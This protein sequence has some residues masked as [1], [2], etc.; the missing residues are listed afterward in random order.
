MRLTILPLPNGAA[1][2]PNFIGTPPTCLLS[3]PR[4]I[5]WIEVAFNCAPGLPRCR[6]C[7]VL[8]CIDRVPL[9]FLGVSF[10]PRRCMAGML[11]GEFAVTEGTALRANAARLEKNNSAE[12]LTMSA[13]LTQTRTRFLR[14]N[15]WVILLL[16]ARIDLF[17]RVQVFSATA[18]VGRT[19]S[20][21]TV[22]R[23]ATS[24]R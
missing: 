17:N 20:R 14:T 21:L 13:P 1:A 8:S 10:K 22:C 4:T 3:L 16:Q 12:I 15:K 6:N 18:L 2:L 9:Q 5:A 24:I 11:N 19:F 7:N 23:K